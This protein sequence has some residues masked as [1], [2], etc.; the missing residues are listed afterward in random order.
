MFVLF[1][2]LLYW[3]M[4]SFGAW[5]IIRK[6]GFWAAVLPPGIALLFNEIVY[7]GRTKLEGYL[8]IYVLLIL[9]FASRLVLWRKQLKWHEIRAQIPESFSFYFSRAGI[10][11]AVL[12]VIV[13]WGGPAFAESEKAADVW[14]KITQ[15]LSRIRSRIGDAFSG[16][17]TSGVIASDYFGSKL[18][19]EAGVEPSD[20]LVMEVFAKRKPKGTGRYYWLTR[21][22]NLYLD[23]NWYVDIGEKIDFFPDE[24]DL[25][26]PEYKARDVIE[27]TVN[28]KLPV[29]L[30][31]STPSDP[32]WVNRTGEVEIFPISAEQVD[33]LMIQSK[34]AV[35]SGETYQSRGSIAI[36]TVDDLQKAGEDYPEWVLKHYLQVPD[37]ITERTRDLVLKITENF[38]NPYDKAAAITTWLRR[39]IQ[40]ARVTE[41]PP[42]DVEK[43]DWFLFDYRIGFCNW[44]ASTEVMLLRIIGI[45]ARMV[46]GFSAGDYEPVDRTYS[47]RGGDAHAWPEVFFPGYGWV[48]F[49]PTSSQPA[50]IRPE[51]REGGGSRPGEVDIPEFDE[52]MLDEGLGNGQLE[53]LFGADGEDLELGAARR[54]LILILASVFGMV[55]LL[56]FIWLYID[57]IARATTMVRVSMGLERIGVKPPPRLIKFRLQELTPIGKIYARLNLWLHRLD[58]SLNVGQTPDERA[59]AFLSIYPLVEKPVWKIVHSY[60]AE[61]FG[62]ISISEEDVRRSWRELRPHLWFEWIKLKIDP[63]VRGRRQEEIQTETFQP[64]SRMLRRDIPRK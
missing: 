62:R 18:A 50:L 42:N 20:V 43:I 40:Y 5:T 25:A 4:G 39:N 56:V 38:D 15:P 16:L 48:E 45:P 24:G 44:Y 12:L 9:V 37:E 28:P 36:P 3:A 49:E 14:E 58:L 7:I 33:P 34:G 63:F 29:I 41:S 23:G 22:Y 19:L 6:D 21:V 47:V 59:T 17:R 53:D 8:I 35:F 54:R 11:V 61:R 57:P 27:V 55:A 52:G 1:L 2:A 60:T 51:R 31:L 26:V 30:Q 10:V 64:L 13:A 46:V 32:L